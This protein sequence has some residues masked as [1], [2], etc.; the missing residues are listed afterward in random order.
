MAP[1]CLAI[2]AGLS[3]AG[4]QQQANSRIEVKYGITEDA[5]GSRTRLKG[6]YCLLDAKDTSLSL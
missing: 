1:R 5:T 6:L 4:K 3:A 2:Y